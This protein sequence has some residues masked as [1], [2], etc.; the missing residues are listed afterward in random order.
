MHIKNPIKFNSY[1]TY[2]IY[3]IETYRILPALVFRF[4]SKIPFNTF[5]NL[6]IVFLTFLWLLHIRY[7][8]L[9]TY[10]ESNYKVT[11]WYWEGNQ[12]FYLPL[13]KNCLPWK[14]FN[15]LGIPEISDLIFHQKYVYHKPPFMCV[16][17]FFEL[18]VLFWYP[19]IIY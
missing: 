19:F 6:E 11:K 13:L 14:L 7:T 5:K 15:R 16:G 8:L 3:N 12:L 4:K 10:L 2:K 9:W 1:K 18:N 17:F